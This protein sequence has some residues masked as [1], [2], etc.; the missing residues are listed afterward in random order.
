M[1]LRLL[2]EG[3]TKNK[4]KGNEKFR[5]GTDNYQKSKTY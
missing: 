4:R 5:I 3:D 1:A 2:I